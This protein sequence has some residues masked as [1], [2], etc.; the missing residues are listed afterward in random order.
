MPTAPT[1]PATPI[2]FVSASATYYTIPQIVD[3]QFNFSR[4]ISPESDYFSFGGT[5]PA[6][7]PNYRSEFFV[8]MLD[9]EPDTA[10]PMIYVEYAP[11]TAFAEP[12]YTV[13]MPPVVPLIVG[14]SL[15][16]SIPLENLGISAP[17]FQLAGDVADANNNFDSFGADF[18]A[19]STVDT[20]HIHLPEPSATVQLAETAL[21][22]AAILCFSVFFRPVATKFFTR[23]T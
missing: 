23:H 18:P 16:V 2:Y 3:F 21:F 15:S 14:N 1:T 20:Q 6:S 22:L 13:E 17:I 12:F 8:L 9:S 7:A 11:S 19:F 10:E 4:P 5:I